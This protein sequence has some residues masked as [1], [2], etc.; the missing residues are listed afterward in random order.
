MPGNTRNRTHS[1]GLILWNLILIT[2]G[3][4]L[5]AMAINGILLPQ[6]FVTGGIA[7]LALVLHRLYPRFDTGFL[8][9]LLNLPLFV[10]AWMTVGRRFFFY[11]AI[12][13][14][15]LSGALYL[16]QVPIVVHDKILSALLAGIIL[17][18]GAGITLRSQGSQGGLDILSVM[19][20]RRFSISLGNT[21]LTVNGI[22]LILV[23]FVYSLEAV[24]Y[25]LI[26]LYVSSKVLNLVVTG[27]S[28]RKAVIIISSRWREI[29]QEI[30]KDIRRGV[31]II[32]G[33]GGF[34]GEEEH[35]LYVVIT[36]QELGSLKRL[37]QQ[38]DPGAFVVI[39][40]TLEVM[41]YRI[42]NQPR[43]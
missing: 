7:G 5:C 14:L 35:I 20:L 32:R 31:T 30:L 1:I 43:W 15:I 19:L 9:I 3:S 23:T 22:V 10:L 18:A 27:L 24:L 25:T 33:E 11:S 4:V 26:V 12:G 16:V 36:F 38:L 6:G 13:S 42:G 8:Y 37:I 29:S 17:G 39:S 2:G 21:I 34:S 41:N 28:Q 40:D